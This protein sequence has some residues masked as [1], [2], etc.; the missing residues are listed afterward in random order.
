MY[1]VYFEGMLGAGPVDDSLAP[2]YLERFISDKT[3]QKIYT[4][5]QSVFG[6]LSELK[7]ELEN[8]FKYLR[9]YYPQ[10]V[11]PKIYTYNSTFNSGVYI[12]DSCLGIGLE[13]YLGADNEIIKAI[14][15]E[16][17]PQFIKNNMHKKNVVIDAVRGWFEINYLQLETGTDFLTNIIHQGKILYALDALLPDAPDSIKIRWPQKKLDWCVK[18]EYNIWKEIIDKNILYTSDPKVI[19]KFT[20]EAPFTAGLPQESP[21]RVGCW[22]GWQMVKAYMNEFPKLKLPDLVKENNPKKILKYYKPPKP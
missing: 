9:Y 21:G 14:P 15:T 6:D 22:L 4:H 7:S 13:M 3:Q 12:E 19:E 2:L 1:K 18:N 20:A 17:L 5:I 11:I 10:A 8:A 16:V